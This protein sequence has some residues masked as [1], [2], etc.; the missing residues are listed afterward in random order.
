[1]D[2]ARRSLWLIG[3]LL[4]VTAGLEAQKLKV[5]KNKKGGYSIKH[6]G[7]ITPTMSE[8]NL[9]LQGESGGTLSIS[10]SPM[11]SPITACEQLTG[12]EALYEGKRTNAYPEEARRPPARVQKAVGLKDGCRARYEITD[13]SGARIEEM[14]VFVDPKKKKIFQLSVGYDAGLNQQSIDELMQIMST[15][16][17][18]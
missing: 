1:M 15:F 16:T 3:A 4:I 5:T 6:S 13:D 2:K 14:A 17:V 7:K 12:I 9:Y 10:V 11:Y 8:E 18:K